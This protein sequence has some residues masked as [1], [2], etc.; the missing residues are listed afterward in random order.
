[1]DN[2]FDLIYLPA[3]Q[4]STNNFKYD[5]RIVKLLQKMQE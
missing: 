5:Q 4:P 1:M 3:G 2:E